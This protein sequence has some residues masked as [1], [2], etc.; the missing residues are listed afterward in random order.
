MLVDK[1]KTCSSWGARS[2]DHIDTG[3]DAIYGNGGWIGRETVIPALVCPS[4]PLSPKVKTGVPS[5]PDA[6]Q[7]LHGNYVLC[8][9][10]TRFSETIGGVDDGTTLNGMFYVLSRT[11]IAHITD[12]STRG[13]SVSN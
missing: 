12:G 2:Q 11:Q 1:D 13:K 10:S 6:Q 5:I 9:G 3:H 7:G 8:A 4:D